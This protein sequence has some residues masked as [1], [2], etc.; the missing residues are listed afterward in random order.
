MT[1]LHVVADD[2]IP[3][4]R[5]ALEPYADVTY[6]P[7]G[8]ISRSDLLRA[9]ALLTRTRTLCNRDLL[10][11]TRVKF[12]ATATIGY[13]HIDGAWCEQNGIRWT[14]APGCNA[15][16][17][18]QYVTSALVNLAHRLN[19][20]LRTKTLGV[21]GIGNV[22][23][24]VVRAAR[25]LGMEVLQCDPPRQRR[26]DPEPFVSLAEIQ[27]RADII[28]MHVPL[29][30]QGADATWHLADDAFFAACRPGV[31]FLNSS[32][33][34]VTAAEALK[35]ALRQQQVAAAVLDVWES[36]PEPDR[37]LLD[38]VT[39]ATPHIAGYSTDG[40]A[41]GTAMS[42]RALA[43][44]FGLPP[45]D[46]QVPVVPPPPQPEIVI[47]AGADPARAV[48]TAVNHSY[49]IAADDARLRTHPECFEQLRGDYPLRREFAAF[50]VSG[51]APALL[52]QLGFRIG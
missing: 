45:T 30:R 26:G 15:G 35:T 33:G 38:L 31:I 6:L 50:K 11:G 10:Q 13:D 24:K 25:A 46:W 12:V 16:S 14:A 22:G 41:N 19:F 2:K 27:R 23:S 51:P 29:G 47:P 42:V 21:V 36:E 52:S 3:F 5:G 40:K 4:L 49:D 17:V 44:F 43:R 39:F 18:M 1:R 34:E 32:R 20:D 8:K 48:L 28:T 7:G 37:E 9:D